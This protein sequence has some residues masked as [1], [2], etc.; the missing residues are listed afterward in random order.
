LKR[1]SFDPIAEVFD[2]TRGPPKYVMGKM[3]DALSKELRGYRTI[4]DAGVGTGRF[5]KPVQDRKFEVVGVDIARKMLGVAKNKGVKNLVRADVCFLPFEKDFFEAAI[6]NAILHLIPEWSAALREICRVTSCVMVSTVHER[7]N[8]IR[9]AYTHLLEQFGYKLPRRESPVYDLR[10]SVPPSKSLHISS[11]YVNARERLANMS[12][13][14]FSFQWNIPD[15]MHNKIMIEL[16]KRFREKE[17][18][19]GMR[20]LV[21]NVEDLKAYLG[22]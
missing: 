11:Y 21:W 17:F 12:R 18:R 19:Q 7:E 20:L 6:C 22:K 8:P 4:L 2:K 13:R 1:T 10:E 16:R 3:L 9:Q 5:A 15:D 14:V